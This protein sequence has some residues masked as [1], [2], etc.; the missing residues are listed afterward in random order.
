MNERMPTRCASILLAAGSS[1]RLGKPKQLLQVD[2]ETLLRRTA[3]LAIEAGCS[4]NV[5]VLGAFV[6]ELKPQLNG[7]D[8]D[9]VTN[10]NWPQGMGS[11]LA[12]AMK[13]LLNRQT[14]PAA[15]LVLVCDQPNLSA[16][17]MR[18]LVA[19]QFSDAKLAI[20]SRYAEKI[21][22]PAVFSPALFAELAALKGDK[23]ARSILA[24][25]A[26]DVGTVD[27]PLGEFDIDTPA[28][29]TLLKQ[30]GS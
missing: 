6:E 30:T 25:Y 2:G 12:V 26:R 4:P 27:F 16:D 10:V 13:W 5:V 17:L 15:I 23:G 22:V 9:V 21:G 19:R 28:D 11:S 20:A 29:E 14:P 7:L 3:R 18:A 8:V 1:S 24:Q